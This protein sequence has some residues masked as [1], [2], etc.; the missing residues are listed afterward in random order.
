MKNTGN[1]NNKRKRTNKSQ[2]PPAKEKSKG[3]SVQPGNEFN[4]PAHD[5]H[6]SVS[7]FISQTSSTTPWSMRQLKAS[8][9]QDWPYQGDEG[10]D[11]LFGKTPDSFPDSFEEEE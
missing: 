11:F 6:I 1:N 10:D 9:L 7:R 4:I 8:Q 5:D 3:F 2:T